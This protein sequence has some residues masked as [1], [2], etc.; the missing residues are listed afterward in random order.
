[1]EA[2][3]LAAALEPMLSGAWRR[4]RNGPVLHEEW[5]VLQEK[6]RS[7]NKPLISLLDEEELIRGRGK[8]INQRGRVSG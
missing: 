4:G 8:Q 2:G 1:M 5:W 3:R 6:H 7:G